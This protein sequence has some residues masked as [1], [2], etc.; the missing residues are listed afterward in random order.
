M[1]AFT[2]RERI[3]KGTEM[4]ML[5]VSSAL[6]LI[7][8]IPFVDWLTDPLQWLIFWLWFKFSGASISK[9]KFKNI[10][11][12]LVSLFP[13]IGAFLGAFPVVLYFNIK[14]IC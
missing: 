5:M 10:I 9:N 6:W 7:G 4:A 8:L 13:T 2:P 14:T 12:A 11:S 1:E 3:G